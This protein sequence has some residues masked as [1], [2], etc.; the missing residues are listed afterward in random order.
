MITDMPQPSEHLAPGQFFGRMGTHREVAGM[1]LSESAY[2]PSLVI[3]VHDH[4]LASV[5]LVLEGRYDETVGRQRRA[6]TPGMIIFHPEGEHHADVHHGAPVRLLSIE[7]G[8]AKLTAL[9]A[10]AP[11]LGESAHLADA[12]SAR[13]AAQLVR[14]FR[15]SDIASDLAIESLMLELLVRSQRRASAEDVGG[16][17]WLARAQE[18]LHAN[19]ARS[20][21]LQEVA[22]AA[23]VHATHLARVFRRHHR[24]TIG[25]YVRRLRIDAARGHLADG[26]RS[27]A[28]IALAAGF[29][30]QSHFSR[31]FRAA[32]GV[33]PAHYRRLR[34]RLD[35]A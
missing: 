25:A 33:T 4:E 21:S 6:C 17:P 5:C 27:L 35:Q 12:E 16:P 20:L 34:G 29:A 18:F 7:L 15:S 31:L 28:D 30:D 13:T 9:Q 3:P 24:C 14:E 23:G 2:A 19:F 10:V 11:V 1:A 8:R 32:T 22:S 26:E